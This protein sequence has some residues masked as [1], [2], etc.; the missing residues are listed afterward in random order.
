MDTTWTHGDSAL[1]LEGE[2]ELMRVP[3]DKRGP[4]LP[5]IVDAIRPKQKEIK[6]G[7]RRDNR[8]RREQQAVRFNYLFIYFFELFLGVFSGWRRRRRHPT[9]HANTS[10]MVFLFVLYNIFISLSLYYLATV[11]SHC[12]LLLSVDNW[13]REMDNSSTCSS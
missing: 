8:C 1:F 12:I 10:T 6:L 13:V 3:K 5:F 2:C 11:S 7:K 9:T 4:F